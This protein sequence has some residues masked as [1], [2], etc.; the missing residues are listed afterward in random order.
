MVDP[1]K[2]SLT[3]QFYTNSEFK[4]LTF[5]HQTYPLAK[6]S[7]HQSHTDRTQKSAFSSQC[8]GTR[9]IPNPVFGHFISAIRSSHHDTEV[10]VIDKTTFK[11]FLSV[12]SPFYG[13]HD[14]VIRE[15]VD[16]EYGLTTASPVQK[17]L[18]FGKIRIKT[19]PANTVLL[20]EG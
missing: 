15:M 17:S 5:F 19:I 16:F 3:K 12:S 9:N 20:Q 13:M 6:V 4:A 11:N 14:K 18:F 1:D 2:L 7:D 10:L 8:S